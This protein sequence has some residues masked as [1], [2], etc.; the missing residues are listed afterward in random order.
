LKLSR[1]TGRVLQV[2]ELRAAQEEPALADLRPVARDSKTLDGG[3][4]FC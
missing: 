2:F 1:S 3:L 4:R